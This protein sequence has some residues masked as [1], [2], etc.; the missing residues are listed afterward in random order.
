FGAAVAAAAQQIARVRDAKGGAAIAG[1]ASAHATN[2]DLFVFRR[3]L[4]GL[5]A[6]SAG[7]AIP[8]WR[9]DDLLRKPEAAANGAGARAL[10]FEDAAA[11]CER[12]RSGEIAGLIV[13][14][15][16]ALGDAYLRGVDALA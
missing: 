6:G 11:L 4:D 9:A 10:G 5:G 14:G 3:L 7:V 15:H 2:E 13:L 12:I 1:I 8:K 16:D